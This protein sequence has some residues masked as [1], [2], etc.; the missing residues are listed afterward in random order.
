MIIR[1]HKEKN[2]TTM[3]NKHL[4]DERLSWKA[5]GILSYLL[6]RPDDWQIYVQHLKTKSKDGRDGT[7]TGLEELEKYG[8]LTKAKR[9]TEAGKFQGYD[10]DV[11]EN[12]ENQS[13]VTEKPETEKP[14][15]VN[16]ELLNTDI[17]LNTDNTNIYTDNPE[18]QEEPQNKAI[19]KLQPIIDHW[20]SLNIK[21]HNEKTLNRNIANKHT[22]VLS[23]YT[24]QEI[25]QAITNYNSVLKH[26][27]SYF[28]KVW[29]LWEF[30]TRERALPLFTDDVFS[31]KNYLK[32]KCGVT[33]PA[34][35]EQDKRERFLR[36]CQQIE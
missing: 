26:P 16:P 27:N 31:L 1:I 29:T 9:R 30:L 23:K 34:E 32:S 5:K 7:A 12:P 8:Y 18:T 33:A 21:V 11:M 24:E 28:T 22:K 6:S 19:Q 10:Y 15:T 35:S 14:K 4:N 20:N 2:F 13:T 36:A 17:K 3:S 25:K